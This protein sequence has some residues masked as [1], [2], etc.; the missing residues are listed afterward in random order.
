MHERDSVLRYTYIAYLI[1]TCGWQDFDKN[2]SR[3]T[4]DTQQRSPRIVNRFSYEIMRRED[5][6]S[7]RPS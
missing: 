4:T 1:T 2:G 3:S 7:Y 5:L 6:F